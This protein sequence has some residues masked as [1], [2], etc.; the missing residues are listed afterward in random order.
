MTDRPRAPR[1]PGTPD[2]S[3]I[4][5]ACRHHQAPGYFAALLLGAT[6]TCTAIPIRDVTIDFVTGRPS[7]LGRPVSCEQARN[8]VTGECGREGRHFEPRNA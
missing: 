5:A 3:R 1:W 4:C 8:G 7:T 2:P 6:P